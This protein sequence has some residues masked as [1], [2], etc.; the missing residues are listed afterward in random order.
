MDDVLRLGILLALLAVPAATDIRT[1]TVSDETIIT[2]AAVA[3]FLIAYDVFAGA[4]R[5]V[6]WYMTMVGGVA[7]GLASS[8]TALLGPADGMLIAAASAML[9][10]YG[11]V[12][13][14]LIAAAVG[15]AGAVAYMLGHNAVLNVSDM[16]A[17]RPYCGGVDLFLR[18][19]K[20]KG[21]RF[22]V[23][24]IWPAKTK[25]FENE[26]LG[27]DGQS[28]FVDEDIEGEKVCGTYPIILF[29]AA[30]LAITGAIL[31]V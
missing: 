8:K 9:P 30:M 25:V 15:V 12:Q 6:L 5:D 11:G 20:R 2:L 14:I 23:R 16:L 22:A 4:S 7:I 17:K 27:E 13:I 26:I 21:E 10:I 3:G 28:Y 31:S 19:V 1:R 29:F 24:N 18:H